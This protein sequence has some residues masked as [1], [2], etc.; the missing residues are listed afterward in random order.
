MS[1]STPGKS[2]SPAGGAGSMSGP[3]AAAGPARTRPS[4]LFRVTNPI[5]RR[6]LSIGRGGPLG[7]ALILIRFEGRKSHRWYTTPVAF[8]REDDRLVVVA[9]AG[10]AW[11]RN[12]VGGATMDVRI[13]GRWRAGEARVVGADDPA[14]D[15]LVAIEVRHRGP[16]GMRRF[17]VQ[18]DDEGGMSAEARSEAATKLRIVEI[19]LDGDAPATR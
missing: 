8:A 2:G 10:S 3:D 13:E 18:V 7:R 15:E 9:L 1:T 5:M 14:F 19:V 4:P 17:G 6:L 16:K 12:L 11:W